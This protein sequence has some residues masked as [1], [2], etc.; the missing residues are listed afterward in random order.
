M[1]IWSL[2]Y[3]DRQFSK[4]IIERDKKCQNPK[5]DTPNAQLNCSHYFVRQ[6]YATRYDPE[7]S[8]ALCV[9]C[10]VFDK[11][12]WENDRLKEYYEFM[13]KKLG[14]KKF[15]ALKIKHDKPTKRRDA[16]IELMGWIKK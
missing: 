8:I 16:I 2:K 9:N 13:L 10:H 7:N 11:D 6:H 1:K 5:C 14:K 4:W 15:E 12:N 3:A